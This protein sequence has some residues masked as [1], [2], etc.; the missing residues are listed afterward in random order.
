LHRSV[1]AT[2]TAVGLS[3]AVGLPTA[4]AA[5]KAR[6]YT[7]SFLGARVSATENVFDIRGPGRPGAQSMLYGLPGYRGAAVEFT[8]ANASGTGGT[9]TGTHYDG[10]GT[11]VGNDTYTM[12]KPDKQG[13][14]TIKGTG[15]FVSGTGIYKHV[16]GNYKFSGTENTKTGV[17]KGKETGTMTL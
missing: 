11:L 17:L 16:R 4:A 13:I 10:T 2:A 9:A 7:L 15:Q 5:S 8:K 14:V 1:I 3:T 6:P 12:S